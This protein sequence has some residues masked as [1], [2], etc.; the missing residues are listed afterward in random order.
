MLLCVGIEEKF[1]PGRVAVGL[2]QMLE[3]APNLVPKLLPLRR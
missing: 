1:T 3:L 2:L